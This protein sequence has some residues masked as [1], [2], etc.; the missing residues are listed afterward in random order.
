MDTFRA[1]HAQRSNPHDKNNIRK[2]QHMFKIACDLEHKIMTRDSIYYWSLLDSTFDT[3]IGA[4]KNVT[5]QYLTGFKGK[6]DPSHILTRA[7]FGKYFDED[8]FKFGISHSCTD[9]H[10]NTKR[11]IFFRQV[12]YDAEQCPIVLEKQSSNVVINADTKEKTK[13]VAFLVKYER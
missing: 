7:M 3:Y 11:N 2:M 12:R 10:L 8:I 6:I 5:L 9:V 13:G 4:E 1:M